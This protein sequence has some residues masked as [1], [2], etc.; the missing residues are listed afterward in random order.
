[1]AIHVPASPCKN[2]RPLPSPITLIGWWS[3]RHW[4]CGKDGGRGGA[5]CVER[6]GASPFW[7]VLEKNNTKHLC[8]RRGLSRTRSAQTHTEQPRCAELRVWGQCCVLGGA[9][10]GAA[11]AAGRWGAPAGGDVIRPARAVSLTSSRGSLLFL[12]LNNSDNGAA[13][14]PGGGRRL[15]G[16]PE[17]SPAPAAAATAAPAPLSAAAPGQ[18]FPYKRL[19]EETQ[20]GQQRRNPSLQT[21]CCR[22]HAGP[23]G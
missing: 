20:G 15:S 19:R 6:I 18:S 12:P 14:R 22:Y 2:P 11:A 9:D 10:G 21:R 16:A 13:G 17:S 7:S 5:E 23:G 3:A 1:M 4:F 8:G